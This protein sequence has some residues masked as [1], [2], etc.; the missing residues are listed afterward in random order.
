VL[1]LRFFGGTT[2]HW[3]GWCRPLD[4]IDFEAREG[5]PHS[6][7]WPFD[8]EHLD[9][10]YEKAH[11]VCEVGSYDY[12]P[13]SVLGAGS[14]PLPLADERFVTAIMRRSPPTRF[15]RAYRDVI[16]RSSNVKVYLSS[17][18]VEL[19]ANTEGRS[20]ERVRVATLEG[21]EFSVG[22]RVFILATGAIENAR[23]LLASNGVQRAGLGNDHD[24]VGRYFMEHLMVPGAM[25]LPSDADLSLD[26]Y[27]EPLSESTRGTG[28][29][30]VAPQLLRAERLLNTRILIMSG[31]AQELAMK[32]SEGV[33]SA[34]MLWSA[35]RSGRA[36][37]NFSAHLANVIK[38]VDKIAIYSYR[39]A[40][41]DPAAPVS[42]LYQIEQ[43]PN[44]DSRVLLGTE[45]D[46]LGVPRVQIDWRFGEPERRTLRRVGEL[47]AMEVGRANLGR[48]H[49]V[50]DDAELGWPP[51]LRGS[52]HQMGTTRMDTD[53]RRGVVDADCRV[54][55]IANLFVA[56]S[57]VFPSSGTTNPTLTILALAL[58]LATHIKALHR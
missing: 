43:G 33:L 37:E 24:L 55:G 7:G 5:I 47:L 57:S 16:D 26:A 45:T 35:A 14:P 32:D 25:F 3:G 17:N 15:G 29:L 23:L 8:K 10:F 44:P 54:H 19:V 36:P 22:A 30:R 2:N 46:P 6:V 48:V 51:G 34:A 20:V 21:A 9:P 28:F 49:I 50:E 42:L 40:F 13:A 27:F 39:R 56:G 1:R 4:G 11:E 53:P 12:D 52:W 31:G 38:D 58:R 18:V 41:R